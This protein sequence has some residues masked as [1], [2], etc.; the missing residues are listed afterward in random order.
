MTLSRTWRRWLLAA[1]IVGIVVGAAALT[2]FLGAFERSVVGRAVDTP[3]T[4]ARLAE[5]VPKG[6]YI[7][8]AADCVACH[9]AEGGAPWAGGRPFEMPIGTLFATNIS[10]DRETGI[11]GWTRAEFHRAVRDG[12]GKGGRHLYPAMPYVSYRQMTEEDV[13]AVYAYLLT[14][15]AIRQPNRPGSFPFPYVRR[16]LTFW[17]L[18]NLPTDIPQPDPG[19]SPA[20]NRGRYLV[21]ALGH[22]GECHTRRDLTMGMIPSRYLQGAVIEGVDAPDITPEGLARLGFAPERLADFMRTGTG[23]QGVMAFAMY[24]V[25][26]HSTQYLSAADAAAMATYLAG[27]PPPKAP[28]VAAA[29][30]AAEAKAKGHR[31]YLDV[32]AGCHGVAGEGVPNV[33]PPMTTN[34]ALRLPRPANLLTVLVRGLPGRDF[35]SGHL[36]DMPGFSDLLT[37]PEIADLANYLRA[38]WGGRSPDV[39]PAD[40]ARMRQAHP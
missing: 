2:I 9:T 35:P 23:P 32:C 21:D 38:T 19:K 40:V 11:G 24:D 33:A 4:A 27:E 18:L 20:W 8:A 16:F 12:V 22:C 7:A 1:T 37:D 28:A 17:N 6:R 36:Q 25:V 26:H 30:L 29:A 31:L 13:D 5:L 39:T 34:A 10:P 14:R 15:E 3:L